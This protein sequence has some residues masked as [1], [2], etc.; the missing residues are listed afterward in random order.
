MIR[1]MK[2]NDIESRMEQ[3]MKG[4]ELNNYLLLSL[5]LYVFL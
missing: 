2:Y 4:I 3:K 5:I 1:V